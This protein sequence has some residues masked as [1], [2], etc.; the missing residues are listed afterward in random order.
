M[1]NL[2]GT[3]CFLQLLEGK[4]VKTDASLLKNMSWYVLLSSK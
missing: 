1:S 2:Y 3:A 4:K